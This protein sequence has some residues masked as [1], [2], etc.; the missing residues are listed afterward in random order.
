MQTAALVLM[1]LLQPL[2]SLT[3]RLHFGRG[4]R[5]SRRDSRG[6]GRAVLWR[7]CRHVVVWRIRRGS[8]GW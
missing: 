6:H 4:S 5:R 1:T 2:C 3:G 7:N 8:S